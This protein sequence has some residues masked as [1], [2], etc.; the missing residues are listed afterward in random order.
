MTINPGGSSKEKL[1]DFVSY[2]WEDVEGF[3]YIPTLD[4]QADQWRKN[5]FPW[6]VAKKSAVD[7]I[8]ESTALGKDVYISPAIYNKPSGKKEDIRGSF[9][10]WAD[11][12]G[13]A[14]DRWPTVDQKAPS[15]AH[16]A[17]P[18]PPS[19]RIQSSTEDHQHVYWKLDSFCEDV[20]KIEDTNRAIAYTVSA[21]PSG[22]DANQLLRPI[23]TI[24]IG[25]TNKQLPVAVYEET[26]STYTLDNFVQFKPVKLGIV[27][28]IDTDNLPSIEGILSGH[29]WDSDTRELILKTGEQ[30]PDGMRA[31]AL[32][33]VGYSG[34]E[35]G[36]SDSEL[37]SLLLF[38]DDKWEKYKG[39]SD[40][41]ARLISIVAKS[42]QKFPHAI[43]TPTFA[44]LSEENVPT[45]TE[46]KSVYSWDELLQAEFKFDWIIEDLLPKGGLGLISADPGI[47]KSQLMFRLGM[48]AATGGQWLKWK[49]VRPHKVMFLSLEMGPMGVKRMQVSM[50]RGTTGDKLLRENF[51]I[52][53]V[54]EI[55]NLEVPE[56]YAWLDNLIIEYEIEGLI[57]DSMQK[58]LIGDINKDEAV[59]SF[60]TKIN[61]LRVLRGV[62]VFVIHHNRKASSDNKITT[63]LSDVYGSQFITA[64]PELVINIWKKQGTKAIEF[65]VLKNR[66]SE[67]TP[68]FKIYRTFNLDF[69]IERTHSGFYLSQ[70]GV[71]GIY[72]N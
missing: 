8:L 17:A 1:S 35:L 40:R 69:V 57:V 14:P 25:K 18:V 6:P 10:L 29:V 12:D 56:A 70:D 28:S 11:F 53:P 59:R 27:D 16:T 20:T 54:Q 24:N 31:R 65:R 23:E 5:F 34:A 39:R 72:Y 13:N 37:Y 64:E 42:K 19:L 7:F 51:K 47:G 48:A 45:T 3:V 30:V 60:W 44:G 58:S 4:R 66:Y 41:K 38:C 2:L 46:F 32:V 68:M 33:R 67:E 9:V 50:N 26:Y 43:S 62:W 71:R 21:D 52:A 55:V 15:E 63:G 36:L 22:W 61:K 49:M